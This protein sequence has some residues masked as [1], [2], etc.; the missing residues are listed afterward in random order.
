MYR[1]VRSAEHPQTLTE[2]TTLVRYT[3]IAYIVLH[4]FKHNKSNNKSI[5]RYLGLKFC[6]VKLGVIM[7]PQKFLFSVI[8]FHT[9]LI[10]LVLK[11]TFYISMFLFG[12]T[13]AHLLRTDF[14]PSSLPVA[15]KEIHDLPSNNKPS[16]LNPCRR[17]KLRDLDYII[18]GIALIRVEFS[19]DNLILRVNKTT[20]KTGR[21]TLH[22]P[23][24]Q[25]ILDL[26]LIKLNEEEVRYNSL[27]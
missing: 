20:L 4:E 26:K 25:F 16:D 13:I 2:G 24:Y 18:P 7:Y 10:F 3:Y 14:V 1:A 22:L 11:D 12:R 27:K 21:I 17:R 15:A 23:N 8:S 9:S 5:N 19:I 6:A